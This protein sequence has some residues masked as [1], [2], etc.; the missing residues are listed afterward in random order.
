MGS[1]AKEVQVNYIS[2]GSFPPA[3]MSYLGDITAS[4]HEH[5]FI[6]SMNGLEKKAIPFNIIILFQLSVDSTKT[7]FMDGFWKWKGKIYKCAFEDKQLTRVL[8]QLLLNMF[9]ICVEAKWVGGGMRSGEVR[10]GTPR[11][12]G[13]MGPKVQS[14]PQSELIANT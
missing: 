3:F 9:C 10:W 8:M 5:H 2:G 11:S 6:C 12:W 1:T 4:H 13:K 7:L 14:E